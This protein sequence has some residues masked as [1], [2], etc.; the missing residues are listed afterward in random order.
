MLWLTVLACD[1]GN[2]GSADDSGLAEPLEYQ[3]VSVGHR[4]ACAV[5]VDGR[6]TCWGEDPEVLESYGWTYA[7]DGHPLD[8][9][10]WAMVELTNAANDSVASQSACALDQSGQVTCWG[11]EFGGCD[12]VGACWP[13]ESFIDVVV[14]LKHACGRTASGDAYCWGSVFGVGSHLAADAAGLEAEFVSVNILHED[15]SHS[16]YVA[17][18]ES[19]HG[20]FHERVTYSEH[21]LELSIVGRS[22]DCVLDTDQRV[23]CDPF[24]AEAESVDD[25]LRS[26]VAWQAPTDAVF[27]S[28]FENRGGFCALDKTGLLFCDAD[29]ED[30]ERVVPGEVS[31]T[32]ASI[33]LH[34]EAAD[35]GCGVELDGSIR[36]WGGR[37]VEPDA[38]ALRW[39]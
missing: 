19:D 7:G 31:G 10:N 16:R 5:L 24:D 38:A 30:S 28:G 3:D 23:L 17:A 8:G 32:F 36:C 22:A 4:Q 9:S 26:V 21:P 2:S 37:V 34:P 1:G 13:T 39:P 25:G 20:W 29:P 33:S 6:M 12:A 15:G 14:G 18:D 11:A 35:S 27:V